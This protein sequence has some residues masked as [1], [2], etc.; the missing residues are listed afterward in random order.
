ML[1]L[2]NLSL[3]IYTVV[4]PLRRR[5]LLEPLQGMLLLGVD[6]FTHLLDRKLILLGPHPPFSYLSCQDAY[7]IS[8]QR[9]WAGMA[10]N[11]NAHAEID[12]KSNNEPLDLH[13]Y[14][15]QTH[16][17]Q[18]HIQP[19]NRS[20]PSSG[21]GIFDSEIPW[22]QSTTFQRDFRRATITLPDILQGVQQQSLRTRTISQTDVGRAQAARLPAPQSM[23]E[24]PKQVHS[25]EKS[26]EQ[27]GA[28]KKRKNVPDVI[29]IDENSPKK[30][31][32]TTSNVT[33]TAHPA[34]NQK[35]K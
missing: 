2:K 1:D 31:S 15:Y 4:G 24:G 18:R 21:W 34:K 35:K 33:S 8:L 16:V 27:T 17:I 32:K 10:A 29:V 26:S 23:T 7:F 25:K 12:L 11:D 13:K 14:Q 19:A 5:R 6:E 30:K 22:D 9:T 28:S 3:P 20:E